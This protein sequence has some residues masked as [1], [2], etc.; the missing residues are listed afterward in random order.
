MSDDEIR[1]IWSKILAGEI[2]S[3]GKYYKRTLNNLKQLERHE[4][5][6]FVNLCKYSIE[7]CQVPSFVSHNDIIPYNQIQ[8]LMDC[9]FLNPTECIWEIDDDC[10][11]RLKGK[12][13]QI[14]L[15]Q[16]KKPVNLRTLTLTDTGMQICQLIQINSDESFSNTLLDVINKGGAATATLL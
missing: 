8:S 12:Q 9:G 1:V 11:I 14:K 4:A 15:K 13:I 6:W 10:I 5:E 3:P 2:Q 16:K 7:D